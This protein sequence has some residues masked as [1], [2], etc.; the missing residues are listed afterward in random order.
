METPTIFALE[1]FRGY[2]VTHQPLSAQFSSAF[3]NGDRPSGARSVGFHTNQ[4]HAE[5][6]PASSTR[7]G[8]KRMHPVRGDNLKH[9]ALCLDHGA[10][11]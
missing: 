2:L 5:G 1:I 4:N 3:L 9:R 11:V 7:V 8:E 10:F 6:R